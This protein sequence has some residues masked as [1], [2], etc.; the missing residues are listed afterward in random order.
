MLKVYDP[1]LEWYKSQ[2]LPNNLPARCE[3]AI[4]RNCQKYLDCKSLLNEVISKKFKVKNIK[5]VTSYHFGIQANR[6]EEISK[7]KKF[8]NGFSF[9]N[10]CPESMYEK[11]KKIIENNRD[12]HLFS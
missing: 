8:D 2:S 9:I 6:E 5:L 1:N 12:R 7:Y 10:F 3:Y 11:L 4:Q